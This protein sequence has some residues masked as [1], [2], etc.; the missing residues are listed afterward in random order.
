MGALDYYT[1]FNKHS[2][3]LT[4][5]AGVRDCGNS[6]CIPTHYSLFSDCGSAGLQEHSF[7]SLRLV[8]GLIDH[9]CGTAGSS[10][11]VGDKVGQLFCNCSEISCNLLDNLQGS[12]PGCSDSGEGKG[13]RVCNYISGI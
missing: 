7:Y 13:R 12:S 4:S 5:T 10:F 3:Y 11:Q 1:S 8:F 9:N 2:S 6:S